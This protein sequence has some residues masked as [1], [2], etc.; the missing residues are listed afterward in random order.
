ML[1]F[2]MRLVKNSTLSI[3]YTEVLRNQQYQLL[4]WKIEYSVNH[5]N[6]SPH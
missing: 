4:T 2:L 5:N 3:L 6:S 1:Q